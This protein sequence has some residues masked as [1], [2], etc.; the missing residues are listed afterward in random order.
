MADEIRELFFT[1]AIAIARLGSSTT[2]MA[3]FTWGAGHSRTIGE[4]RIRPTW[5]LD[6]DAQGGVTPSMPQEL[7]VRDGAL[8]RPVAPFLELWAWKGENADDETPVPVTP[9]LLAAHGCAESDV[10][11]TVSAMNF[12]VARRTLDPRLRYGTF[13]PV[14]LR[15]NEHSAVELLAQSPPGVDEPLIPAGR[16]I[17]LGAIHVLRPQP[18]PASGI[19]DTLRLDVLRLRFTPARGLCYGPPVAATNDSVDGPAVPVG[20]AFLN[21]NAGWLDATSNTTSIVQPGD[22]YD[23]FDTDD[24]GVRRSL[25]VV[26]D[27]CEALVSATLTV[28]GTTMT[29][30]A[31]IM[32]GP[33][34]FAPDRRPFL[35]LADEINDRQDDP[36]RDAA[37]TP[38]ERDAWVENLFERAYETASLMNVDFHRSTRGSALTG[39]ALAPPIPGDGVPQPRRAMGRQD[40]LRDRDIAISAPLPANSLPLSARARER[41]R[42]LSDLNALKAWV[43]ANP[44][45]LDALIRHP[46]AVGRG[47]NAGATTMQMPPFMRNSNAL[48]LTLSHWQ[49]RLLMAWK[50]DLLAGRIVGLEAVDQTPALST[51]AAARRA[52]VLQLLEDQP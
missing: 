28:A 35:S 16:A 45:R 42:S 52:A 23:M 2:P 36:A 41:H 17:P 38:Q 43:L 13:P 11:F 9:K 10:T 37:L 30:R 7:R 5:T 40:A 31:N 21:P 27:T 33:P 14:T 32:V 29:A 15:A 34:H 48:P 20:R 46:F 39:P 22:T 51:A 8:P 47:E 19:P 4:T 24:N 44:D 1:P 26:D 6:V 18:Q 50:D 49:H 12:K 3:A 25:G